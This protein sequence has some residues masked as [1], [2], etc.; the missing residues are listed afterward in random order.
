M[1]PS[2]PSATKAPAQLTRR[3]LAATLLTLA[4]HPA[5]M[6][7]APPATCSLPALTSAQKSLLEAETLL[8]QRSRWRDAKSLLD[9]VDSVALEKALDA[10][11]DPKTLKEQAMNNAAFI[12]YYEERRYGDL[13]LEP[14]VPSLRAEQV[15]RQGCEERGL[16]PPFR[17]RRPRDRVSAMM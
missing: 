4:A 15:S 6:R 16:S 14:Q 7:A 10:C 12:V 17:R 1:R 11:V 3:A 9:G 13:R 8:P 2:Q 5:P